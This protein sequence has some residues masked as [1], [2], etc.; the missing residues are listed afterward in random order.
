MAA[1]PASTAALVFDETPIVSDGTVPPHLSVRVSTACTLATFRT[2]LMGA[3]LREA[4]RRSNEAEEAT[5]SKAGIVLDATS[6][7]RR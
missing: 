4:G 2:P 3:E 1:W 5:A 6:E 7:V